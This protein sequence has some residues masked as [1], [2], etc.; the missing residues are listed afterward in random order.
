MPGP[1]SFD[2]ADDYRDDSPRV[3]PR[4]QSGGNPVLIIALVG[5][6]VLVV[7]LLACG[8][9]FFLGWRAPQAPERQPDEVALVEPAG[10][11]AGGGVAE[12][13]TVPGK[14]APAGPPK[15]AEPK[16]VLFSRKD[17]ESAVLNKSKQ[18]V[19]DAVGRPDDTTDNVPRPTGRNVIS[20]HSEWWYFRNRV[21][22][23]DTGKPYPI[24][25]VWIDQGDKAFRIDYP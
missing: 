5:G 9:L 17:F 15:P 22:N 24:A 23:P 18:Q 25:R 7:A 19:I 14:A 3:P 4:R 10:G 2:D 21:L 13:P 20:F 16:Q 11:K 8:G 6:A 12:P 1:D